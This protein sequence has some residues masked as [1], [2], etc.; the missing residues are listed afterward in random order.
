MKRIHLSSC[1]YLSKD[2]TYLPGKAADY[3][4][5]PNGMW[6]AMDYRWQAWCDE[7]DAWRFANYRYVY[8][9]AV[10]TSKVCVLD[11]VKPAMAFHWKY[12]YSREGNFKAIDWEKVMADYS[13]I[14]VRN[15]DELNLACSFRSV[16]WLRNWDVNSGCIWDLSAVDWKPMGSYQRKV[17]ALPE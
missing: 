15:Y 10:D 12:G 2:V 7:H 9:L 4:F 11:D 16:I 5:K 13:G 14:E 6:Y 1:E 3:L 8:A 17:P